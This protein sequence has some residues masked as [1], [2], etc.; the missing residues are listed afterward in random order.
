VSCVAR[1]RGRGRYVLAVE[2]PLELRADLPREA[3]ANELLTRLN[4][5]YGRWIHAH[6]EQWAWH[7]RRW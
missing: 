5:V 4:D 3:A 6:P 2:E 1:E 7:Q